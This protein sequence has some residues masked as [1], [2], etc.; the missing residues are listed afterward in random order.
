MEER[1]TAFSQPLGTSAAGPRAWPRAAVFDCDGLLVDSGHCWHAAYRAAAAHVGSSGVAVSFASL[2]GASVRLAAGRL[3]RALSRPV[4]HELLREQLQ[5]AVER[6]PL[7]ATHGA[8]RL[9]AT[10]GAHLPLAVASNGPPAAVEVLLRRTGLRRHFSAIVSAEQVAA[11]KPS[12]HVYL[13]ACRQL[14]VDPSDAIAFEDSPRG[15]RAARRAGLLLVAVPSDGDRIDADL[16]V[17][18]LDDARVLSLFGLRRPPAPPRAQ[19]S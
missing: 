7:Q 16:T 9:L 18:R 2:N 15:A 6:L 3:S 5:L 11:P 12:P 10:L 14:A 1:V 8:E 19:P 13:E 4:P 17:E